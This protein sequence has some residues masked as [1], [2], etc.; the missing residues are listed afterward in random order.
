MNARM[1]EWAAMIR[2]IVR[3]AGFGSA[4]AAHST[5]LPSYVALA[6]HSPLLHWQLT[7][8]YW[9]L[10]VLQDVRNLQFQLPEGADVVYEPGDVCQLQPRNPPEVCTTDCVQLLQQS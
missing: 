4:F 6:A 2:C 9:Q 10:T 5:M 1:F 8:Y 7:T 3:A